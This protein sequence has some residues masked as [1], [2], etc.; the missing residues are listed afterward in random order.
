MQPKYG[1]ISTVVPSLVHALNAQEVDTSVD[2]FCA[3][4][5]EFRP[6][7]LDPNGIHF[8]PISRVG[9]LRDAAVRTR[10]A[11]E[12]RHCD[13]VHIHGLWD[14]TSAAASRAALQWHKPYVLS[15]HGM[16]EPWALHHGKLKKRIYSAL[17]ERD[18]VRKARCLHALTQ[19]EAIQ[20][21][22][23]GGTNTPAVVI[24]NGVSVP[25]E[26]SPEL[27]LSRYPELRGRR[28]VLFLARLHVKKG[29]DLLVRA[30]GDVVAKAPDAVLVVA[31]PDA[32]G[33]GAALQEDAAS[34]GVQDSIAFTGMLSG[35]N[36]WSAIAAAECMVLPSHSEGLS[37]SV[38]EAM[39]AGVPVL[40]TP[41]CNMPW[42]PQIGAGWLM[43]PATG[44][45]SDALIEI[46]SRGKQANAATGA[47]GRE[48][49]RQNYSWSS[50]AERIAEV[51]R[52]CLGDN[53]P[54]LSEVVR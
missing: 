26:L 25:D 1:G 11:T 31:G 42:V 47:V 18:V 51:Y 20:C 7:G 22:D 50:V 40:V 49:I 12:V 35:E 29:I 17:I 37:M 48:F 3:P 41:Q 19:A 10:F 24:P 13:G 46:L 52:W 54:T 5:E 27:F 21:R 38:L 28:I 44:A 23:F 36:K 15:C 2:A 14:V 8:W 43:E 45:I 30:W 9:W 32:D 53:E 16:L 4:G 39:G 6:S 34:R 33:F